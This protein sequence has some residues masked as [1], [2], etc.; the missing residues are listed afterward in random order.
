M[1]CSV[2]LINT[3]LLPLNSE[4]LAKVKLHSHRKG[5]V[6]GKDGEPWDVRHLG[7]SLAT[8]ERLGMGKPL[9]LSVS[10][11]IRFIRQWQNKVH[12]EVEDLAI[13]SLKLTC[14]VCVLCLV[15]VPVGGP[16]GI[17]AASCSLSGAGCT[18]LE[19]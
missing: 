13:D 8:T 12:T 2:S 17:S 11:V 1:K 14:L 4:P 16:R 6:T 15:R 9:W 7:E 10:S 18:S 19:Q 3:A 5:K